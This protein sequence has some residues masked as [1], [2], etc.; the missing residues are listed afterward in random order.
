MDPCCI[1]SRSLS[2]KVP[3]LKLKLSIRGSGWENVTKKI[4]GWGFEKKYKFTTTAWWGSRSPRAKV[5]SVQ[6]S[7][8][9]YIYQSSVLAILLGY[10]RCSHCCPHK[11]TN[12]SMLPLV[13]ND[14]CHC[15][16][17]LVIYYWI[18]CPQ[19]GSALVCGE[20][21]YHRNAMACMIAT[22]C[23]KL[24]LSVCSAG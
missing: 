1:L 6:P 11:S 10:C 18:H 5:E 8:G 3:T 24:N 14:I 12:T 9:N 21:G 7:S 13:V 4:L 17:C 22:I 15:Q 20:W 19:C 16:C 23:L 2:I